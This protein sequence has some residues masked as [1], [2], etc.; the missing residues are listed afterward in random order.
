MMKLLV[1]LLL[2]LAPLRAED[3]FARAIA[4]YQ[5]GRY[6]EAAEAYEALLARDGTRAA[7]LQN[8]GS[9]YH[10]LGE[11]GRAILAFERALLLKPRDADLKANLKLV[12]DHAASFPPREPGGAAKATAWLPRRTWS[13]LA[14]AGAGMLPVGAIVWLSFPRRRV[15]FAATSAAIGGT[16]LCAVSWWIVRESA[17]VES[18]AIVVAAPA[19][20]R[21]SPFPDAEETGTLAA[22]RRVTVGRENA[23]HFWI[24][25]DDAT[26]RGWV[27]R[28]EIEP[29]VPRPAGR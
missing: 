1:F 25:T 15:R 19:K 9:A 26:T 28:G 24:E 2:T 22:G 14:L 11:D 7:V 10:R 20:V 18:T 4:D 23:G 12:R 29:L 5:A 6:R 17:H 13:L 8:L 21:L 3:D 27:A 16:A